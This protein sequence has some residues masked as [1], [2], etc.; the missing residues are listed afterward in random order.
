MNRVVGQFPRR[1]TRKLRHFAGCEDPA[2]RTAILE[3]KCRNSLLRHDV[4][5][6]VSPSEDPIEQAFSRA[7][8][9]GHRMPTVVIYAVQNQT[10]SSDEEAELRQL[11]AKVGSDSV[12][13]VGPKTACMCELTES[14]Q[15]ARTQ[16]NRSELF[17]QLQNLGFVLDR[18]N[19][20]GPCSMLADSVETIRQNSQHP[21]AKRRNSEYVCFSAHRIRRRCFRRNYKT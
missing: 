14:E 19:S 10:L 17:K 2:I 12:F 6:I 21:G 3:V 20:E 18:V 8:H 7:T 5:V 9:H 16:R 13:F 4:Q 1:S 11:K 15:H